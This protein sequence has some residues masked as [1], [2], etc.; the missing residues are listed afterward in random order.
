MNSKTDSTG[1]SY[2]RLPLLNPYPDFILYLQQALAFMAYPMAVWMYFIAI[3][4]QRI[5]GQHIRFRCHL[6]GS[7]TL[8]RWRIDSN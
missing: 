5:L 8:Q 4:P 6:G 1:E 7:I 3:G 2:T